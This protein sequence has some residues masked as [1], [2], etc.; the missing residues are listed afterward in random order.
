M[1]TENRIIT[2]FERMAN[3]PEDIHKN[4]DVFDL[5]SNAIEL[6]PDCYSSDQEFFMKVFAPENLSVL[7]LWALCDVVHYYETNGIWDFIRKSNKDQILRNIHR[8]G[9]RKKVVENS[10]ALKTGY[11]ELDLWMGG[12]KNG[13]L[14]LLGGRPSMGKT[15]FA[16]NLVNY[17]AVKAHVPTIWF[18]LEQSAGALTERLIN[19]RSKMRA[20]CVKEK[21]IR[22]SAEVPTTSKNPLRIIDTPAITIGEMAEQCRML[23]KKDQF[24]AGFVVVDYFQLLGPKMEDHESLPSARADMLKDLKQMTFSAMTSIGAIMVM[25]FVCLMLAQVLVRLK[26]PQAIVELI[27]GITTNK[28]IILIIVNLFLFI[29]GMIVNDTTGMLICAPLLLP[30]MREIGVSTVQF[31]AIMGVNLAMGGVTPPY[32]SIL[33]LGMR[34]GNCEFKDIFGPTMKLLIFGYV[35]VVFL[36][37]FIPALSEFLPRLLGYM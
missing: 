34:V 9:D 4:A 6:I 36:T 3:S 8:L 12:F 1:S 21:T 30:L 29:V 28:V 23:Q 35:P 26:V 18:S 10:W 24:T 14:Y 32:A 7:P 22:L 2:L 15:A 16:V 5:F 20:G 37:S 17:I 31:A 11:E 27:F 13:S 19:L 25:I 33:Y